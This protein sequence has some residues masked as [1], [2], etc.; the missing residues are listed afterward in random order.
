M[1]LIGIHPVW[2]GSFKAKL[3]L[4]AM[5]I[6]GKLNEKF[7]YDSQFVN[8]YIDIAKTIFIFKQGGE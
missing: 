5:S 6:F 1:K 2:D 7:D 3:V 4:E 8:M